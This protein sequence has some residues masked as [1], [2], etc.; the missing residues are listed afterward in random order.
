MKRLVAAAIL[1]PLLAMPAMAL[2]K[3]VTLAV[4]NM[5]CSACPYTVK[6]SLS[7]IKGVHAVKVSFEKKTATVTFDDT[8]ADVKKLMQAT[9]NA[10]YPS[11]VISR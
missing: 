11:T 8:K 1:A 4:S 5:Y 10:G 9:E 6:S 7:S 2:E 3:T